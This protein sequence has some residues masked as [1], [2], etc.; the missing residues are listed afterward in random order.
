MSSGFWITAVVCG[1]KNS[2]RA[3]KI[4]N[5][6]LFIQFCRGLLAYIVWKKSGV[7]FASGLV[8]N[9][10]LFR[11]LFKI[12]DWCKKVPFQRTHNQGLHQLLLMVSW[13]LCSAPSAAH[14]V[15]S[16]SSGSNTRVEGP[17][18]APCQLKKPFKGPRRRRRSCWEEL[19][20]IVFPP[21]RGHWF[22]LQANHWFF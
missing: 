21:T 10:I 11:W 13:N 18:R 7:S 6:K 20:R 9:S 17:W 19:Q 4:Y 8:T 5:L 12:K 3:E 2:C 14:L 22:A 1:V 15:V 16:C